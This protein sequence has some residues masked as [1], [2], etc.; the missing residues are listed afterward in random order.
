[1]NVRSFVAAIVIGSLVGL[2]GPAKSLLAAS[3]EVIAFITLIMAGLLPAM[4]LTATALRGDAFSATR[5]RE[6]GLRLRAQL[7]FWAILFLFALVAVMGICAAKACNDSPAIISTLGR[8]SVKYP[9]APLTTGALM[10][11]YASLSVVLVRLYPAYKGL[12]SL[13][14]LTITMA[15]A[16]ALSNDRALVD[17]LDAKARQFGAGGKP[18]SRASWSEDKSA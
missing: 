5:V 17:A 2:C 12:R 16:Q 6:L 8:W 15:E 11:G 4:M 13:L 18:R 3:A 10:L 9:T 7:R 1:M 14:E